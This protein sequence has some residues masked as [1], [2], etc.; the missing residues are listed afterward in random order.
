MPFGIKVSS[1]ET[2]QS[3]GTSISTGTGFPIGLTD[4]GP[5]TPTLIKSLAAYVATYGERTATSSVMYDEVQLFFNLGGA[6]IYAQRAGKES[7]A[8]AALKELATGAAPKAL[9]VTARYRG[10]AG[11]KI[12]V[13]ASATELVVLNEAGEILEA[14]KGVKAS[15]FVGLVSPYIVVT[16]G[17]EF[18]AGKGE[19]L[20]VVAA[21][22]LAG[23]TNPAAEITEAIAKEALEKLTKN[24]GPGQVWIPATEKEPVKKGIHVLMGEHCQTVKNNRYAICD[25]PDNAATAALIASKEGPYPAGISGYMIFHTGSCII[26]GV[27]ANT[28]RKVPGSGVIAALCAQVAATG[29]DNQAPIGIGWQPPAFGPG[30]ISGYVIGFTNTFTLAQMT[31]LSEAGINAWYVT[32]AGVPCLYG[33]VSALPFAT[34]KIFWQAS[35]GRERMHLVWESEE[36]LEEFFGKTIDGRGLLL[37]RLQGRLQALI[38]NHWKENALFGVSAATAGIANVGEPINTPVTEQAGEL[39]AELKVRISPFVNSLSEVIVSVP[40]S[41]SV[42]A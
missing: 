18:A 37:A 32:P 27:T 12:K 24:L 42:G 38:T 19:A 21:A 31:E 23:G 41:E 20:K 5:F 25:L 28:T 11:N 30:G 13:E 4:A 36:L 16:E 35:A 9:V 15:E 17:G 6:Q 14:F 34:D 7:V 40:I 29:N 3:A 39:N 33:F 2:A 26:P 22:A 10:T 1:S 8:V